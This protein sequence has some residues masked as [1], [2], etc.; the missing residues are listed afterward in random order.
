MPRGAAVIRYDGKRGVV[1]RIKYRDASGRQVKETLG[2]GD[3]GMT[4]RKAEAELRARLVAVERDGYRQPTVEMFAVFARQ[5][6]DTFSDAKQH[7]RTTRHDYRGLV[8]NHLIPVF[9]HKRIGDVRTSDIDAYVAAK[10]RSGLGART[11]N[12]HLARLRSIFDTARRQGLVTSNPVTDAARPRV[13]KVRWTILL[14]SEIAAVMRA[15][16]ELIGEAANDTELRW[17]ETAKAMVTTMQYGWLRRGELL[18]LRWRAVELSHPGEPRLHIRET[19]VRGYRSDPKTDDGVRTIALAPPLAE[20]LWQHWRRSAYSTL[21][22]L[23]FCHPTKGTPISSGY[24]GPIVKLAL[25]RAGIDRPMREFHDW[26]HTGITNAAAAGMSPIKIMQMAGHSDFKTT[27][28]YID[29]ASVVFSDEVKL[30][31]DWYG[32]MGTKSGVPS[33]L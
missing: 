25:V 7:R 29:L 26:R 16:D 22:D 27:A 8:E 9:G 2:R 4:R 33:S 15:F 12:Q 20:E 5:W 19:W 31:G 18:G 6:L 28:K 13:P 11:L 17:R 1:W 14:P 3:A 21:D 10:M 30:L 32:A 24:F 23:V